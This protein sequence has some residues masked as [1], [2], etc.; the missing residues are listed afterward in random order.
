MECFKKSKG[1]VKIGNHYVPWGY[2]NWSG[3][4]YTK[5]RSASAVEDIN[6]SLPKIT[7]CKENNKE[8]RCNMTKSERLL[9]KLLVDNVIAT[10]KP[11]H[12]Q[13][14]HNPI[15]VTWAKEHYLEKIFRSSWSRRSPAL[16]K[17]VRGE[18]TRLL[19]P[20][21][22]G[23]PQFIDRPELAGLIAALVEVPPGKEKVSE[24]KVIMM[25]SLAKTKGIK[26]ECHLRSMQ[27]ETGDEIIE[28]LRTVAVEGR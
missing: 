28:W 18:F 6:A 24:A 21:P 22:K 13:S 27:T 8:G 2:H 3:L 7:Y 1:L 4:D 26:L 15:S 16:W 12:R 5:E 10:L 11:V 17:F 19:F 25:E 9:S 14:G 20:Y 23:E